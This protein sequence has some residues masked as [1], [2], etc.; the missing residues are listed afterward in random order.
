MSSFFAFHNLNKHKKMTH[1][2]LRP[3][4]CQYCKKTFSSKHSVR[5]HERQHTNIT[6]YACEVCG[7]GFRQNVSLKA[8]KKSKHNI[9]EAKTSECTVCGKKIWITMG[10]AEPYANSL[11]YVFN[12]YGYIIK[13]YYFK[14]TFFLIEA[15]TF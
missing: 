3:F 4:Q 5:T 13:M 6:P 11:T 12:L 14:Q 2:K 8:H 9:I 7:E 10:C 15:Y 1:M